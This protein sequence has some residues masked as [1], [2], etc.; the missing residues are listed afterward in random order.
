MGTVLFW[1]LLG[2]GL[3]HGFHQRRNESFVCR[4]SSKGATVSSTN[5]NECSL[6]PDDPSCGIQTLALE[7]YLPLSFFQDTTALPL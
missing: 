2:F 7:I 5:S 3:L 6:S 4:V 1:A